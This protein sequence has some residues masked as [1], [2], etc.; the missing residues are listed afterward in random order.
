VTPD[1]WREI[2][3]L[4]YAALE[5][6]AAQ[7]AKFLNDACGGDEGLRREVESLLAYHGTAND[8]MALPAVTANL[9]R[10][11][12][13]ASAV[14]RTQESSAPGRLVGRVFGSYEVQALI[15]AGGMGEVYRAVDT[16]LDRTVAIKTLHGQLADD[17]DRQER[18]SRE[19]NIVSRLNHPHLHAV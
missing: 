15:A 18:F 9:A 1:R 8:F 4:Y 7:R 16:R 6:D 19:A 14:R 5:R 13:I 17:P 11:S 12:P 2:E 3:R 10:L